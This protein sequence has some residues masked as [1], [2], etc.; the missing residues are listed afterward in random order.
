M[1]EQIFVEVHQARTSPDEPSY[2]KWQDSMPPLVVALR[3]YPVS[4]SHVLEWFEKE[5]TSIVMNRYTSYNINGMNKREADL[6]KKVIMEMWYHTAETLSIPEDK[7]INSE[8][9]PDRQ[10]TDGR[11][12]HSQGFRKP[13]EFIHELSKF[14]NLRHVYLAHHEFLFGLGDHSTLIP[15]WYCL[16]TEFPYWLQGCKNLST[17]EVAFPRTFW[18]GNPE[19]TC[20]YELLPRVVKCIAK[21]LGVEGK[22]LEDEDITMLGQDVPNFRG[23]KDRV[24][25]WELP[26]AK[27]WIG[28]KSSAL[29]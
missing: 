4:Y 26:K 8:T 11:Q 16:S 19:A 15:A 12:L 5:N 1:R 2:F 13:Y 24:W 7:H 22:P 20:N 27:P 14:L 9:S 23:R 29:L 6:V 21:K 18:F 17:V 28:V 10:T 25:R 3:S